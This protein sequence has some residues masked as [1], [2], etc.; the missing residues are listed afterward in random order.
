VP[1]VVR[2]SSAD[3]VVATPVPDRRFHV[4]RSAVTVY[5]WRA[6]DA[7]GSKVDFA[8]QTDDPVIPT[9]GALLPEEEPDDCGVFQA[10]AAV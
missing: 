5:A 1:C 4:P 3:H 7:R 10:V 2:F 8:V 6:D 9:P